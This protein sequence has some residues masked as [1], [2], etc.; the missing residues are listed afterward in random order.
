MIL[1]PVWVVCVSISNIVLTNPGRTLVRQ[2][3]ICVHCALR[4]AQYFKM[5]V[6]GRSFGLSKCHFFLGNVFLCTFHILRRYFFPGRTFLGKRRYFSGSMPLTP[7]FFRL[8]TVSVANFD[9]PLTP[10]YR[11]KFRP[12]F[13]PGLHSATG[14]FFGNFDCLSN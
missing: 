5:S 4:H 7:L 13:R 6:I 1:P 9:P 14:T 8:I 12:S 2:T 3:W 11:K 10:L